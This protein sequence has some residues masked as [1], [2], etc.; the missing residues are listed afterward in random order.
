MSACEREQE[1]LRGAT[2]RGCIGCTCMGAPTGT[3]AYPLAFC[4][5]R[6]ARRGRGG[7]TWLRTLV[8]SAIRSAWT[9]CEI[10]SPFPSASA[11]ATFVNTHI[12]R[13]ELAIRTREARLANFATPPV[14]I[15]AFLAYPV[16]GLLLRRT[17]VA[18][19]DDRRVLQTQHNASASS[20]PRA[21]PHD[22]T[23]LHNRRPRRADLTSLR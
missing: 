12:L 16:P 4:D 13:D 1:L 23:Y 11:I 3:G 9:A 2:A 20:T 14:E 21:Q 17:L 6:E 5:G 10:E 15:V 22:A 7:S 18:G 19:V 8:R